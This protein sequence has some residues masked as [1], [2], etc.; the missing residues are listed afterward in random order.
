MPGRFT[1]H[2]SS[3]LGTQ[4]LSLCARA[5]APQLLSLCAWSPSC[6][7]CWASAPWEAHAPQLR[8]LSPGAHAPQLLSLCAWS[9]C[10]AAAEASVLEPVLC[11]RRPLEKPAPCSEKAPTPPEKTSHSRKQNTLIE[12]FNGPHQKR[13][14]ILKKKKNFK[15][16]RGTTKD[17]KGRG[18]IWEAK[19]NFCF[20]NLA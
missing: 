14:K 8:G 20:Y 18:W 15:R 19:D 3:K 4:L 17:G 7:R 11:N 16:T 9:P 5:H 13:K 12:F 10:A 1:C 6:P 2:R